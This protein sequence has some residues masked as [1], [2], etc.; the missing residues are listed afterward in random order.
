MK[1]APPTRIH[2]EIVELK[3]QI[4]LLDLPAKIERETLAIEVHEEVSAALVHSLRTT[5]AQ[6]TLLPLTTERDNARVDRQSCERDIASRLRDVA[7]LTAMVDADD[8]ASLAQE[9]IAG[10]TERVA[11]AQIAVDGAHAALAEINRLVDAESLALEKAQSLAG[12]A[13]LQAVKSG[14]TP[15]KP[16]PVSRGNLDTLIL[17]RDAAAAELIDTQEVLAQCSESLKDA[18]QQHAQAL[19]DGTARVLYLLSHDYAQ[20]LVAH[21]AASYAS[22]QQFDA[23]DLDLLV[24]QLENEA[25]EGEA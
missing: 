10:A 2:A 19:A 3:N 9:Q 22:G 25:A 24:R 8:R 20:A 6:D 11:D 14:K 13:L 15:G 17:A 16:T 12:A 18:Q 1:N 21:K 4:V 7:R 23:P 5:A